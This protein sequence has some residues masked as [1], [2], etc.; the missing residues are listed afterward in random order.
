MNGL[1]NLIIDI[2]HD[3]ECFWNVEKMYYYQN[4][5]LRS[6]NKTIYRLSKKND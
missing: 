2:L 3:L 4:D 5:K 6:R 1:L